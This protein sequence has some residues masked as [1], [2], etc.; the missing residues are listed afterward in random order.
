MAVQF[1]SPEWTQSFRTAVN[2]NA[3]YRTAGKDWTHGKVAYVIEADP[4]LG[5]QEDMAMVLDLHQ[6][7]CRSAAYVKGT[8]AQDADFVIRADYG[9]WKE[10]MSGAVDPTKAMMQN[11]LKL[12]KGHLPTLIKFVVASKQLVESALT[13]DTQYP[14]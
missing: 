9:R 2:N 4:S 6:G 7:E 12:K 14:K 10:V 13:I 3:G 11:K 8:E 1:P 5:L